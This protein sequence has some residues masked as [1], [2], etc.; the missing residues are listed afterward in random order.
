MI[1]THDS[2]SNSQSLTWFELTAHEPELD[3]L[4]AKVLAIKDDPQK[5]CFCA[6][7]HYRSWLKKEIERLVGVF[8][9]HK[10]TL[11][12]TS[13]AYDLVVRTLVNALPPCRN[14]GCVGPDGNFL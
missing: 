4:L 7:R 13:K 1:P 9:K 2:A 8:S 3:E 12:G 6:D 11:L 14:C 5:P 10:G